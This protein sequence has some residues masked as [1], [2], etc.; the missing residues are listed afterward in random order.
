MAGDEKNESPDVDEP[1]DS[2]DSFEEINELKLR[3]AELEEELEKR[4]ARSEP[5]PTAR[6]AGWILGGLLGATSLAFIVIIL[7]RGLPGECDCQD[8]ASAQPNVGEVAEQQQQQAALENLLRRHMNDFQECF[9]SWHEEHGS[10]V[11]AGFSVIIRLEVEANEEGTVQNA[12]ASGDG[13]PESLGSCLEQRVRSWEF[14]GEGPY[15]ME[16]PLD[17]EGDDARRER[18]NELLNRDGGGRAADAGTRADGQPLA[19]PPVPTAD[20]PD[21]EV[22]PSTP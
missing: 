3:I 6:W 15:I 16:L 4:S 5:S 8:E 2:D 14:P 18:A 1:D 11:Q 7:G 22:S 13:L 19:E 21:P 20:I 9:D 12:T 17:V 10:E